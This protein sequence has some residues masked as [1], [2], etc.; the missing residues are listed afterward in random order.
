M[1]KTN[2]FLTAELTDYNTPWTKG[3]FWVI[4]MDRPSSPEH[5]DAPTRNLLRNSPGTMALVA[6]GDS[7]VAIFNNGEDTQPLMLAVGSGDLAAAS[8]L[9][10]K[11]QWTLVIPTGPITTAN[12]PGAKWLIPADLRRRSADG[13]VVHSIGARGRKGSQAAPIQTEGHVHPCLVAAVDPPWDRSPEASQFHGM[14]PFEAILY[15]ASNEKAFHPR[16]EQ[17][18]GCNPRGGSG[19]AELG[20]HVEPIDGETYGTCYHTD[21]ARRAKCGKNKAIICPVMGHDPKNRIPC[22]LGR[23]K[24]GFS[25]APRWHPSNTDGM[26]CQGAL[27]EGC[28]METDEEAWGDSRSACRTLCDTGDPATRGY[29][30]DK[31]RGFCKGDA[32]LNHPACKRACTNAEGRPVWCDAAMAAACAGPSG[33]SSPACSCIRSENQGYMGAAELRCF[34]PAC[35]GDAFLPSTIRD[36]GDCPSQCGKITQICKGT[37]CSPGVVDNI[38]I[39]C[40]GNQAPVPAPVK[41]T[42]TLAHKATG[43]GTPTTKALTLGPGRT[44]GHAVSIGVG[45]AVSIAILFLLLIVSRR[46]K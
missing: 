27:R 43:D 40:G 16:A 29:C 22:C 30:N 45:V 5:P 33:A 7:E 28:D 23:K 21:D 2:P 12:S 41:R 39:Q 44:S 32:L 38:N 10:Y 1:F 14:N 20:S 15:P 8:F 37:T 24:D 36:S 46:A 42:D 26:E 6:T 3:A 35:A 11:R 19:W 34:D 13:L 18:L 17:F 25:C 4:G 31:L 9:W